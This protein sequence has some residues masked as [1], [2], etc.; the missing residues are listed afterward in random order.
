M[1]GGAS[2]RAEIPA[3]APDL[4]GFA[5]TLDAIVARERATGGWTFEGV[6]GARP[7]P[8]TLVMKAAETIA[9]PLGLAHWVRWSRSPG[10]PAAGATVAR[11]T[12]ADG[13]PIIAAA[14]R[15]ASLVATQLASGVVSSEMPVE[16]G[17]RLVLTRCGPPSTTT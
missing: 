16:G 3:D 4:T 17:M 7:R 11:R 13:R 2:G 1:G 6:D 12:S 5:A 8:F 9:A 15:P 10:T 14:R